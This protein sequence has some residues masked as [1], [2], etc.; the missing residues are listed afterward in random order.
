MAQ[1]M[2]KG[3]VEIIRHHNKSMLCEYEG[4]QD[5]IPYSEIHDDS[6][7]WEKSD[8]GEVGDLVIPLWLA[9]KKGWD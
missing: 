5:W 2:W 8:R 7:L 9:N 4:E 1:E 6:E 3:E